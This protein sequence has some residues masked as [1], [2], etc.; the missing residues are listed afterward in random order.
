[1]TKSAQMSAS[2]VTDVAS[3][4]PVT[5][6][7]ALAPAPAP[8]IVDGA[9][10]FAVMLG[11]S[12]ALNGAPVVSVAKSANRPCTC[13]RRRWELRSSRPTRQRLPSRVRSWW[14]RDVT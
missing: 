7:R 9:H 6:G 14:R 4:A 12:I 10:A 2:D 13:S 1:M 3:A 5:N 11:G 8:S